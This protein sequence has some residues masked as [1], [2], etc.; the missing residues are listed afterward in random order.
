M[1]RQHM[2]VPIGMCAKREASGALH[3]GIPVCVRAQAEL[4]TSPQERLGVRGPLA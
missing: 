1:S 2:P 3:S 4:E